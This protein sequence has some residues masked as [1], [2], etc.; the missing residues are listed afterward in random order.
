MNQSQTTTLRGNI[1]KVFYAEPKFSAGRL[2]DENGRSLSFAG[3]RLVSDVA[4]A[5]EK[6]LT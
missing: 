6:R 1:E 5:P 3:N 4:L 2:R